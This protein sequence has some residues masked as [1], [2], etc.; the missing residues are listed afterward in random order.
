MEQLA[1]TFRATGVSAQQASSL[2]M[3][4]LNDILQQQV[5]MMSYIDVFRIMA[6]CGFAAVPLVFLLKPTKGGAA[7]V[8]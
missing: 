2:A 3:A 4:R 1:A 5:Q 6:W 8:H 7:H